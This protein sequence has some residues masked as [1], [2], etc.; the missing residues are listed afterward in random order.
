M[1]RLLL[2]EDDDRLASL[3]MRYLQGHG[4]E[5][6]RVSDGASALDAITADPPDIVLLDLGLPDIDGLDL[7]RAIR[8]GYKGLLCIL[9]ARADD[10]HQVLGLELGADDYISKPVEPRLL[11]ARLRAHLRR[12][13]SSGEGDVLL[14]GQLRIDLA[15]RDV[16]LGQEPVQLTTSEF[17]L[18]SVLASNAGRVLSRDHLFKQLRG[19]G[20]DGMDRSIDA[21]ISRLRRKLGDTDLEATRI[22]TVRGQGYLFSQSGWQ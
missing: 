8:P 1:T 5:L 2:V 4:F 17:D 9:S 10:I 6:Q 19:I 12:S 15:S 20:F 13:Q 14:F 16:L 22:K 3:V 21:R 18:L 7:C 11:L